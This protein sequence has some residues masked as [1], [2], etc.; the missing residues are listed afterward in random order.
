MYLNMQ[1]AKQQQKQRVK[2]KANKEQTVLTAVPPCDGA[3]TA[4]GQSRHKQA[5]VFA[6]RQGRSLVNAARV[7]I[8]RLWIHDGFHSVKVGCI[9]CSMP[10]GRLFKMASLTFAACPFFSKEPL[11]F[12]KRCRRERPASEASGTQTSQNTAPRESQPAHP[13][14]G[15]TEHR[16][17]HIWHP[18]SPLERCKGRTGARHSA[19]HELP[20]EDVVK[21][22]PE[23]PETQRTPGEA[24]L[25][26]STRQDACVR[27]YVCVP[28]QKCT[29][30][31]VGELMI[32]LACAC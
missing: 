21:C 19:A 3:N 17:D 7:H 8:I 11:V 14:D 29:G 26:P 15:C 4:E 28:K 12:P 25:P 24:A 16:S 32:D 1:T 2:L 22:S 6:S 18:T 31:E 27:V 20:R 5:T 9:F 30:H 13:L 10:L 23:R